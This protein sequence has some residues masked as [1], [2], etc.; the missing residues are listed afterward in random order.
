[1][2][3]FC[4]ILAMILRMPAM[5]AED[6]AVHGAAAERSRTPKR[7]W[8]RRATLAA[9]CAAS[10]ALDSW[11]T[12]RALASGSVETNPVLANS[13][14]RANWGR[15][16][17]FKAGACGVSA[18]LQETDTFHAWSGRNADWTWTGFNAA[19]AAGYTWVARHNLEAAGP[20][21]K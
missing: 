16:I 13:R 15:A 5:K 11:S 2:K 9:G 18:I 14:G 3:T 17:A 10:L 20:P 19:T 21:S 1:M 8:I 4:L 6:L 7:I 12:R